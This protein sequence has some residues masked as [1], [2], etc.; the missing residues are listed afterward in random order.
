[1]CRLTTTPSG[2]GSAAAVLARGWA[3]VGCGTVPPASRVAARSRCD[4]LRPPL[5]PEPLRPLHGSKSRRAGARRLTAHTHPGGC[6]TRPRSAN[7]RSLRFQGIAKGPHRGPATRLPR[8]AGQRPPSPRARRRAPPTHPGN[9]R[10]RP[11]ATAPATPH[12]TTGDRHLMTG[13]PTPGS[14]PG[15]RSAMPQK[16]ESRARQPAFTRSAQR[17]ARRP[18]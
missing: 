12:P 10:G 8:L 18:W 6:V 7:F 16:C 4:G 17:P 11:A 3:C 2:G 5:T 15:P 9:H 13:T 1:M 14:G